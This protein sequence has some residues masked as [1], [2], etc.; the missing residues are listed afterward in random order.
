MET[1]FHDLAAMLDGLIDAGET[2]TA[3]FSAE[4]S[5]FVRMNRGKVRQPGA[6]VQRYIEIDLIRSAKHA[7][8]RLSLAGDT[9]ADRERLR[10]VVAGLR[11]ALPDLDDDPHMLNAT[12]VAS[13]RTARGGPLPPVEVVIDGN[14][15]IAAAREFST[16]SLGW[17]ISN[18]MTIQIGDNPVTVQVGLNLTIVGSKDLPKDASSTAPAASE[19]E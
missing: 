4:T 15:L 18:K 9:A 8:H 7:S 13:T 3:N 11:G 16:G 14:K 5:D 10:A 12:D 1:Y 17:N 6:V 19:E 2:Y